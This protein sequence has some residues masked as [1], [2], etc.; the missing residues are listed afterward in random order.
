VEVVLVGFGEDE[1]CGCE[2]AGW[3]HVVQRREEC[4][5][6]DRRHET[7]SCVMRLQEAGAARGR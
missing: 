7:G 3:G 4:G 6:E 5:V 2:G 1:G